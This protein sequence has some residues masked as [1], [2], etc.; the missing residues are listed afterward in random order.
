MSGQL[1]M[2]NSVGKAVENYQDIRDGVRALCANYDS[3][4]WQ[5]VDEDRAYP[6]A[7]VDALTKG[8][9][10]FGWVSASA[11]IRA[12]RPLPSADSR[13]SRHLRS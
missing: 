4:Y 11:C 10:A 8:A 1:S 6:E 12:R 5:K 13:T 2:E 3:A 7:F 9:E